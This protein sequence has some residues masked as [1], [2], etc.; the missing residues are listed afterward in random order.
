ML[1]RITDE[2]AIQFRDLRDLKRTL[3]AKGARTVLK[4]TTSGVRAEYLDHTDWYLL[5]WFWTQAG[6]STSITRA[7]SGATLVA[8]LHL[9]HSLHPDLLQ[10][11]TDDASYRRLIVRATPISIWTYGGKLRAR[12]NK[13]FNADWAHFTSN[14]WSAI[15]RKDSTNRWVAAPY[16][17]CGVFVVD[18]TE[19]AM[20][21]DKL[22]YGIKEWVPQPKSMKPKGKPRSTL[23]WE[24]L[25]ER[26]PE[27]STVG[28]IMQDKFIQ[29]CTRIHHSRNSATPYYCDIEW[30]P[31]RRLADVLTPQFKIWYPKITKRN[32]YEAFQT[33]RALN[34]YG[35]QMV[36]NMLE[37]IGKAN[38]NVVME[39]A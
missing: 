27:L 32:V 18:K 36:S 35:N 22:L 39:Y 5:H 21:H 38:P 13:Y 28:L 12:I 7:Y 29:D 8:R 31:L 10:F 20:Y 23:S 25:L 37:K 19:A 17:P 3:K 16:N 11:R 14:A 30:K 2:V 34:G 6:T 9:K 15:L 26:L 1:K 24:Q 33:L 4:I